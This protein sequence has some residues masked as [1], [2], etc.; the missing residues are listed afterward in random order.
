MTPYLT[1]IA[2]LVV[3]WASGSPEARADHAVEFYPSY[4]PHEIRIESVDPARAAERFSTNAIHAYV[5]GDPF[6][7]GPVP[8]NLGYVESL[9]S[10]LVL[11]FN[12]RS[13]SW[14]DRGRRCGAAEKL[15]GALAAMQGSHVFSPYPVTP[16][17]EDYLQHFDLVE[18]AK[19]RFASPIA[20]GET[21]LPMKVQVRGDLAGRLIP[22]A[23][24]SSGAGWDATLEE[25]SLQDLISPPRVALAGWLGPPWLKEGWY[26]AYL[27]LAP[28]LTDGIV[29]Q[30][31]EEIYQRMTTGAAG[32]HAERLN[33]ERRLVSLLLSGCER[34]VLGYTLRREYLNQS[35]YSEGIENV[36]SDS[37]AGLDSPIFPRTVKL[38]DFLW[39]GW[40][41]LGVGGK[42]RAAW[43]PL[44]GFTDAM[45]RLIWSAVGDPAGFPVPYGASW[46]A[47]RVKA[48]VTPESSSSGEVDVPR[49]ALLPEPGTGLLRPVGEGRTA[50]AKILYR[51]LLSSF[52][53][54]TSMSVADLL[55]P[56]SFAYRWGQMRPDGGAGY[57]PLIDASTAV[58]RNWL[59]GIK[60]LREETVVKEF[61][62]TKLTFR[63]LPVEAY[64]RHTL[65]DPQQLASVAPPW[66]GLPW[67]LIAL[68]EE[69]VK[70]GVAAFSAGEAKRRGLP[71]LDLVRDQVTRDRLAALVEDFGRRGY[72]PAALDGL[73]TADQAKARWDALRQFYTI[74]H[75]FLVTNGP[76][77]LHQ[78]SGDAVVLR[79]FRDQSYPVGLGLFD[80]FSLPRR[81][82]VS[83]L[84]LHEGRVEVHA[85]VEKVFKFQRTYTIVREALRGPAS[86]SEED[87]ADLPVCRYV[88]LDGAGNV[89]GAGALPPDGTG[90]FVI[91]LREEA[92]PGPS[93]V[94]IALYLGQNFVHPQV[95]MIQVQGKGAS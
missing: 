42:P 11:T 10:Y 83:A 84:G 67:P 29:R 23:W 70:R 28:S 85:D 95:R 94:L 68:M 72:V 25:I 60:V 89:L 5:G 30:E 65:A 80:R 12:A 64:L 66:S 48:V 62:E 50:R 81:A 24:R 37:Q 69:G 44:G 46:V 38:K 15:G 21:D 49:D 93:T 14:V 20:Q 19:K 53:D 86:A 87:A 75:H 73:V 26:H 79:A 13:G 31:A 1:L 76:Y 51:V 34:I 32:N 18:A 52:H 82:Y 6:E 57:D 59:A 74:H 22:A 9:G 77:A 47:N 39:N 45:G 71:W 7:G 56:L 35:D 2:W 40:L 88:A 36:A 91:D 61:D 58:A 4:Y 92:R 63:V 55:Y 90:T 78:W 17:H 16:S 41:R 54:Q 8:A 43:N 33:L 3:T 27:L